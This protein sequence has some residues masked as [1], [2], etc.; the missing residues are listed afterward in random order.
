MGCDSAFDGVN[1]EQAMR[2][3]KGYARSY[4]EG[5][6]SINKQMTRIADSLEGE[7]VACNGFGDV[8]DGSGDTV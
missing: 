5:I 3:G 4:S 7:P 6:W 8:T 1:F 2:E